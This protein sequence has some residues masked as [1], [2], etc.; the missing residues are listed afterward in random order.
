MIPLRFQ[1]LLIVLMATL[2]VYQQLQLIETAQHLH[3][4]LRVKEA[5]INER[6]ARQSHEQELKKPSLSKNQPHGNNKAFS[7]QLKEKLFGPWEPR[8]NVTKPCV[9]LSIYSGYPNRRKVIRNTYLRHLWWLKTDICIKYKFIETPGYNPNSTKVTPR[10]KRFRPTKEEL[11]KEAKDYGDILIYPGYD[12]WG[13]EMTQR[14]IMY[15]EYAEVTWDNWDYF[16][17]LDD[18]LY[19]FMH[20]LAYDLETR[21]R[22]NYIVGAMFCR[23]PENTVP[24]ERL[25]VLSRDIVRKILI[26]KY[27]VGLNYECNFG[28]A[29]VLWLAGSEA[30]W[31]HD[32]RILQ[33]KRDDAHALDDIP[34]YSHGVAVHHAY[35][36]RMHI[37]W[38]WERKNLA[39]YKISYPNSKLSPIQKHCKNRI[40]VT[41]NHCMKI[42]PKNARTSANDWN[43]PRYGMKELP[44]EPNDIDLAKNPQVIRALHEG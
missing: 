3:D 21:P 31:Y 34:K 26:M 20:R 16:V 40:G 19:L 29:I 32:T 27:T 43:F 44:L 15:M 38:D 25:I 42:T 30:N 18:D 6:K 39:R 8:V 14:I 35:E 2:I 37:L 28:Q 22:T 11:E 24:D 7:E 10:Q 5:L 4:A 9:V 12:G 17:I 23:G 13:V 36:E 33:L 41:L 1:I